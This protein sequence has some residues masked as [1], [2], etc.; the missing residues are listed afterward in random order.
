MKEEIPR[1]VVR[2]DIQQDSKELLELKQRHAKKEVSTD[3]VS[4]SYCRIQWGAFFRFWAFP[5]P[6]DYSRFTTRIAK[7]TGYV[8]GS[9]PVMT[10]RPKLNPFL[11]SIFE[12]VPALFNI[13]RVNWDQVV[14]QRRGASLDKQLINK[15]LLSCFSDGELKKLRSGTPEVLTRVKHTIYTMFQS[16]TAN[17]KLFTTITLSSNRANY[18]VVFVQ[19][20][21]KDIPSG[22]IVAD[23]CV[24]PLDAA[25]NNALEQQLR[26][27]QLQKSSVVISTDDEETKMWKSLLLAFVERCR[28]SY[29]HAPHCPWKRDPV[30]S[31]GKVVRIEALCNCGKGKDLGGFDLRSPLAKHVYRAAFSPLGPGGEERALATDFKPIGKE[32]TSDFKTIGK[33]RTVTTDIKAM[34]F[35]WH[36]GQI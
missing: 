19:A 35:V 2:K 24:F 30:T 18:A 29:V 32:R 26:E 11:L 17:P 1:Y 5:S 4:L 7:T 12:D 9:A 20:L 8:E 21:G 16:A 27:L 10:T 25:P 33:G 23:C 31:D 14:S 6:V 3:P 28:R 13:S 15:I 36:K 22:S 34:R